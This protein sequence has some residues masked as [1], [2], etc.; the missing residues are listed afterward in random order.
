MYTGSGL[1]SLTEV[2]SAN[3]GCPTGFGDRVTFNA[4]VGTTYR[5]DVDGCCGLPQGSFTLALSGQPA[6]PP[7]PN[8]TPPDITRP[9]TPPPD[10]TITKGPKKKVKTKKNRVKVS[11]EFSS[12]AGAS[13]ECSL[14]GAAFK[15][16]TSPLTAKVKKGKHN[17][18]VQAKDAAGNVDRSP[19]KRAFKVIK[20][21]QS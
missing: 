15:S 9:D 16:C 20:K 18:R 11:F 12:E 1:G 13:F 17:F 3:N 19:A 4:T 10:T 6:P 8:T 7:P 21:K 2:A 5:I 14:D